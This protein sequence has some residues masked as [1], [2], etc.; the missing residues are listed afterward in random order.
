MCVCVCVLVGAFPIFLSDLCHQKY[1]AKA[2]EDK[3]RYLRE[4]AAYGEL[5]T[6]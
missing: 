6:D 3:E 4:K 1:E 5:H 2:N